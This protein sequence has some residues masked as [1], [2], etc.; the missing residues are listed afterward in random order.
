MLYPSEKINSN[1]LS[2][3]GSLSVFLEIV[4]RKPCNSSVKIHFEYREWLSNK[5]V[6]HPLFVRSCIRRA[7]LRLL[8]DGKTAAYLVYVRIFTL[9]Q[10]PK[11][12]Y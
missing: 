11:E 1:R 5:Y 9:R 6:G 7:I 4:F 12:P 10:T 8:A 2:V 3:R